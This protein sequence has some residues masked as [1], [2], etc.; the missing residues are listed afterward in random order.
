MTTLSVANI[1]V[2]FT[3]DSIKIVGV[4]WTDELGLTVSIQSKRSRRTCEVRFEHA[5]GFRM[6]HELDLASWWYEI[7]SDTRSAGWLFHVARGGWLALE[8]TRPDF[9][10]QPDRR[11]SEFL[12]AGY[13][14]CLSVFSSLPPVITSGEKT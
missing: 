12:I 5:S 8:S 6:L 14:E 7:P 11:D 1:Q 3:D 10:S 13:Q 4:T 2:P 9:Y